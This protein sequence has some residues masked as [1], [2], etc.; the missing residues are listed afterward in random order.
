MTDPVF[1]QPLPDIPTV[2]VFVQLTGAEA[3]H[4]EVKRI[5]DGESVVVTDGATTAIRGVWQAGRIEIMELLDLPSPTPRVTIVQALPKSDR[6]E[7]AV[8]LSVQAGA[9]LIIP[10]AAQRSIARWDGKENK[11]KARWEKTAFAAAKQ[12]RRLVI[13]PI[14][15]LLRN[16]SDLSAV[17]RGQFGD[18]VGRVAIA[19]LH[20]DATDSFHD[21]LQS[22]Q[23]SSA[24]DL[25]LVI[26]PEGGVS[27]QEFERI[28]DLAESDS[29]STST[30]VLGPEVLRT[31]TAGAVALGAV[32]VLTKRW[33]AASR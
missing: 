10:W 2:G 27:P 30:V 25:V 5:A 3:R 20:E 6:A 23:Q 14:A 21:F 16:L 26:G 29:I 31:A 17:V 13:P 28:N 8:D 7:L 33:N 22:A 18:R 19:V 32:G 12:S 11:A 24:T 15:D 9:D 1:V 4:S